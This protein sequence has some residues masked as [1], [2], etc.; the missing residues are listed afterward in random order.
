MTAGILGRDLLY[1]AVVQ[2]E[3][4]GQDKAR[5]VT[6]GVRGIWQ[7]NQEDCE[8]KVCN[9]YVDSLRREI[10]TTFL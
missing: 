4:A 9:D 6:P 10:D 1:M 2:G 5:P 8:F 3:K 7:E